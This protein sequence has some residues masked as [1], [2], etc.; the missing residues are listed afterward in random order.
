MTGRAASL[1]FALALAASAGARAQSFPV[2]AAPPPEAA[3]VTSEEAQVIAAK[4][5][6]ARVTAVAE[7]ALAFVFTTSGLDRGRACPLEGLRDV[8]CGEFRWQPSSVTVHRVAYA[9]AVSGH[10]AQNRVVLVDLA[11]DDAPL[12]ASAL[13][14]VLVFPTLRIAA[15]PAPAFAWY[16]SRLGRGVGLD[17]VDADSD[18]ALDAVYTYEEE[19]L[20]V[21]VV[22]RDVWAF[23]DLKPARLISSGDKLSGLFVTTFDGVALAEDGDGWVRRGSWRAV[24]LAAGLPLSILLERASLP[25]THAGF[26][27]HVV[28]DFG[29]GWREVLSGS[30]GGSRPPAA[31][32]DD[33]ND[34]PDDCV[35][36]E[37]P[38]DLNLSARRRLIDLETSC[39]LAVDALPRSLAP[40]PLAV[41]GKLWVAALM[42]VADLHRIASSLEESASADLAPLWPLAWPASAWLSLRVALS[43][44]ATLAA[45]YQPAVAPCPESVLDALA[46]FP[47]LWPVTRPIDAVLEILRPLVR[48]VPGGG[49]GA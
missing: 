39:R 30:G 34:R 5:F 49:P 42:H 13:H 19:A 27:L 36:S 47:A 10:L 48:S 41:P 7:D 8:K 25:G 21:R 26:D 12:A 22:P 14:G 37:V 33:A 29:D 28:A 35:P 31:G 1:V 3:P 6:G 18:G 15:A 4:V 17:L 38:P 11:S 16:L 43:S 2:V 23:T 24:A 9:A 46:A 44:H 45:V 40:D 32:A 20:G